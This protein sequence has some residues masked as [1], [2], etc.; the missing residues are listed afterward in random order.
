MTSAARTERRSPAGFTILEVVIYLGVAIALIGLGVATVYLSGDKRKL[1]GGIGE[2]ELMAKR[3]RSVATLQQ[4]PYALEFHERG[5]GLLPFAEAMIDP[6]ERESFYAE[7]ERAAADFMGDDGGGDGLVRDEWLMEEGM[8]LRVQRWGDAQ[9]IEI[10]PRRRQV[11][12]FD[13]GG[14]CEPVGVRLELGDSWTEV[15]FHPLTASVADEASEF[16]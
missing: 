5:V 3:A 4:K 11:W 14:V 1:T 9:W 12:R 15:I 16:N 8:I 2:V 13:P 7:R 10:S 6:G